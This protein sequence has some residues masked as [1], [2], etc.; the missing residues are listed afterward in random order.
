M[1][2]TQSEHVKQALEAARLRVHAIASAHRRLRLGEDLESAS[3]DE[4]LQAVLDDIAAT[5]A[6]RR[7]IEISGDIAAI[8]VAARDATTIGIL[9]GELVTNALKH[10]FPD[11]RSGVIDVR[12]FRGEGGTAT[13]VVADN[14]VGMSE[15]ASGGGDGLGS[16]I[17]K[18]LSSQ[19][20]GEPI[21]QPGP[22]GGLTV[23]IAMP[24]LGKPVTTPEA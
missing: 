3:A 18:Q 12:L 19:F 22:Q 4:F 24:R 8:E 5:Q 16:V 7:R 11:Q 21:Y 20:G 9:V 23:T 10:A 15:P 1:L 14:G 6:D 2:R 17:V 13:L